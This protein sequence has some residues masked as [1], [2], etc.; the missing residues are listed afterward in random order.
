MEVPET[1]EPKDRPRRRTGLIAG[2]VAAVLGVAVAVSL[3]LLGGS[4]KSPRTA[5]SASAGPSASA[6]AP[7]GATPPAGEPFLGAVAIDAR[8]GAERVR[9]PIHLSANNDV[10]GH[11]VAAGFGFVWVADFFGNTVSKVN[12]ASGAVVATITV[13]FP[14]TV[15]V[16]GKDVWVASGSPG[17]EF[18]DLIRIDASTN[19]QIS[20]K[21]LDV[22]CGGM[23]IDGGSLWVLGVSS[24]YRVNLD[25]G[26][27]KRFDVGGDA[28][29]AGGGRVDVLSRGLATLTPVDEKT[30][31][32][33]DPLALS[34]T[35]PTFLAY[36]FG[37]VW[38]T[39]RTD[40]TV[41]R[42]PADGRGGADT[43]R[44]G[45]SP[46]GVAPGGDA[47][48]VANA[49][50]GTLSKLD[51]S[52]GSVDSTFPVGG[53]PTRVTVAFGSVWTTDVPNPS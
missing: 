38:I 11:D 14:T 17:C 3:L 20:S 25:T 52:G 29:T 7:G 10:S 37:A 19:Q 48:W 28:V 47:M 30:G 34:G 50:D 5:P 6:T 31:A 32:I 18:C 40:G 13:R 16:H 44:V 8:T 46:I 49:G 9:V 36:G 43:V 35:S 41:T 42:L 39:D 45:A 21:A 1:R 24:L 2:L 15:L 33:G 23:V 53:R 26:T 27:A 22:C 4:G 12:P 51:P